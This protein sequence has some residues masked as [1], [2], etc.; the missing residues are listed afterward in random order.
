[1]KS[2]VIQHRCLLFVLQV[3]P[4]W[5]NVWSAFAHFQVNGSTF[6]NDS[7]IDSGTF[8]GH[9]LKIS[10]PSHSDP[11]KGNTCS[12]SQ[13]WECVLGR[14]FFS[15]EKNTFGYL[16]EFQW[17]RAKWRHLCVQTC[18]SNVSTP[19]GSRDAVAKRLLLKEVH[20]VHW[21]A[22]AV[23]GKNDIDGVNSSI[24]FGERSGSRL[25]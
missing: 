19:G 20:E 23:P 6:Q 15:L 7:Q 17:S 8:G 18:V 16:D 4:A 21:S 9:F 3:Y 1:M 2:S 13:A 14:M 10:V 25:K 12:R 22:A 5:T 24:F 11:Y